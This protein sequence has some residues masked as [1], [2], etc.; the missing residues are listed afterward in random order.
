MLNVGN[1]YVLAG[2]IGKRVQKGMPAGYEA[3]AKAANIPLPDVPLTEHSILQPGSAWML[4]GPFS[5]AQAR[6]PSMNNE[7][8]D[9]I[10]QGALQ[11]N[12]GEGACPRVPSVLSRSSRRLNSPFN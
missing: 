12:L 10:V 6:N 1:G 4:Y 9:H 8:T 11:R 7:V 3:A 5:E 2:N